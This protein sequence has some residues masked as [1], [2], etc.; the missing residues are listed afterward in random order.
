MPITE[1]ESWLEEHGNA[2]YAFALLHLRDKHLAEDAVQE[3]LL[4][5]L[6]AYDRFDGK[7]SIRTWL[8][9][10]LK[11]KILDE[12]RRQARQADKF[13]AEDSA[14]DDAEA[15]RIDQDFIADGHWQH[16]LTEWGNPENSVH[17]AQ[18]WDMIERCLAGLSPRAAR[19]F[20]LRE[21]WE[22]ETEAVCSELAISANNL[23]TM[24]HRARMSMRRCF[25]KNGM[26]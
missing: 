16:A 10:I 1:A 26:G 19:L 25:E 17:D 18:F 22:F 8:I 6:Q 12:F 2:L 24:L 5:A 9:G 14:W 3:T 7:A 13:E 20:V 21:I 4:G 11:H 23:W 15:A